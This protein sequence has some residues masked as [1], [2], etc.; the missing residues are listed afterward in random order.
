MCTNEVLFAVQSFFDQLSMAS[1]RIKK[2]VEED[3]KICDPNQISEVDDAF[4]LLKI[5]KLYDMYLMECKVNTYTVERN[6]TGDHYAICFRHKQDQN[7]LIMDV[8]LD[9]VF[10]MELLKIKC[11]QTDKKDKINSLNEV[12]AMTSKVFYRWNIQQVDNKSALVISQF[13]LSK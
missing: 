8:S 4:L 3:S 6:T 1:D 2:F 7:V 10:H 9:K 13:E 12:L 5:A 11:L